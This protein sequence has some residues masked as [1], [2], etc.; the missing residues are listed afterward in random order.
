MLTSRVPEV[1]ICHFYIFETLATMS[2]QE[3]D[4]KGQDRGAWDSE[5]QKSESRKE[6]LFLFPSGR[7]DFKALRI[8]AIQGKLRH[9][10]VRSIAWR[11]FLGVL[12]ED[13]PPELWGDAIIRKRKE[14]LELTAL[15][16]TD[17]TAAEVEDDPL[18]CSA[19]PLSD[20]NSPWQKYY[21]EQELLG[22]IEKDM[23][24]LF[25]EG[26]GNFF[27]DTKIRMLCTNILFLWSQMNPDT[28]YRQGMHEILAPIVYQMTYESFDTSAKV[29]SHEVHVDALLSKEGVEADA[30][31]C[32]TSV[33]H[34]MKKLFAV[35]TGQ[36][37]VKVDQA[38]KRNIGL[39]ASRIT[40]WPV[41]NAAA[42]KLAAVENDTSLTPILKSCNRIHHQLL[43]KVD[44]VLHERLVGM[45]IEPQLYALPWV[46]LL[47][48]R[49]FHI[50]DVMCLWDGIFAAQ[51]EVGG[52][53]RKRVG[54]EDKITE[55][56][57]YVGVAM[58]IFVREFLM[59][60]DELSCLKRLMKYPPVEDVMVLLDHGLQIRADPNLQFRPRQSHE[61]M[62]CGRADLIGTSTGGEN[63][64]VQAQTRLRVETTGSKKSSCNLF[65]NPDALTL[66]LENRKGSVAPTLNESTPTKA[67]VKLPS[68]DQSFPNLKF[69]Y[70]NPK[71]HA[72]VILLVLSYMEIPFEDHRIQEP[73]EFQYWNDRGEIFSDEIPALLVDDATIRGRAS[74]T[75]FIARLS[76]QRGCKKKLYTQ[77]AITNSIIDSI[78]EYEC[79]SFSIFYAASEGLKR[80]NRL[81]CSGSEDDL[82]Q[83][84]VNEEN[85]SRHFD[86]L[87]RLLSISQS[88]WLAGTEEP[89]I[90]DLHWVL[91]LTNSP[92][93]IFGELDKL[94]EFPMVKTLLARYTTLRGTLGGCP[95]Y[96]L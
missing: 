20:T 16:V 77:C 3:V 28:S 27:E 12:P 90:A 91:A 95:R 55:I 26:C 62:K 38:R 72:A 85:M 14:Y 89:S 10:R 18:F 59:S 54:R 64:K 39:V 50:Q 86:Y 60:H 47:F 63:G 78:V 58:I 49:Q 17:P 46:R 71:G 22:E 19:D 32:F 66:T 21:A 5:S 4:R 76:L 15:H 44:R 9:S 87:E 45:N 25:P 11:L 82:S 43:H 94:K 30:F 8:S 52:S 34:D 1:A 79:N 23:T 93:G 67:Q 29:L 68:S 81:D 61:N 40:K 37:K 74:I 24:R 36:C 75:R 70:I 88:G 48:G 69:F 6:F 31:W 2:V 35:Q 42:E 80:N 65:A 51:S 83:K 57:E 53:G 92:D 13:E 41:N 84:E 33:M 7:V 73:R 56:I 96:R